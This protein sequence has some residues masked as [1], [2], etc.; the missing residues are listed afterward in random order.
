LVFAGALAAVRRVVA[1][2]PVLLRA[3]DLRAVLGLVVVVLVVVAISVISP[4]GY[5]PGK[6]FVRCSRDRLSPSNTCL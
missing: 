5:A 6:L 1:G 4:F 3:V 2:V